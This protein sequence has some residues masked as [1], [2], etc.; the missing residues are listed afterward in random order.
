MRYFCC[1]EI[2]LN[3]YIDESTNHDTVNYYEYELQADAIA[4]RHLKYPTWNEHTGECKF[5]QAWLICHKLTDK[6][7]CMYQKWSIVKYS[8]QKNCVANECARLIDPNGNDK[9]RNE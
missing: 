7:D 2:C 5:Q 8:E 1:F 9:D 6:H 4:P 3:G